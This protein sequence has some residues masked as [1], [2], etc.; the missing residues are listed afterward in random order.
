MTDRLPYFYRD[1]EG[2]PCLEWLWDRHHVITAFF[3]RWG[4]G[5]A[6]VW[7]THHRSGTLP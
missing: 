7:G 5:W 1:A 4:M 3:Y 6:F 2:Y